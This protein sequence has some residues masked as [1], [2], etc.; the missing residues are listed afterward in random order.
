MA[1]NESL[2][3]EGTSGSLSFDRKLLRLSLGM[4]NVMVSDFSAFDWSNAYQ[5][6]LE[7]FLSRASARVVG[8][9]NLELRTMSVLEAGKRSADSRGKAVD[10]I[11]VQLE[12][13]YLKLCSNGTNFYEGR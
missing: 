6:Q 13:P 12:S 4:K 8:V 3:L 2:F 9:N 7:D 10:I 5:S 11:E 1:K